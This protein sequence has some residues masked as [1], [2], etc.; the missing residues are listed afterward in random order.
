MSGDTTPGEPIGVRRS[1]TP[2]TDFPD[3]SAANV[4]YD[5]SLERLREFSRPLETTTEYGSPAYVS[6]FRSRSADRTRNDVDDRFTDEDWGLVQ[7][8]LE[9]VSRME[10][11]CLDRMVGRHPE[12]SYCCRL[13]VPREYGRIALAW[14]KLLDPA[15]EDRDPDFYTLQLPDW[16]E[17]AIRVLPDPGVTVVLGSDYTGEAKKSFLR[18]FMYRA[19]RR[20]GLGLHAGTKRLTLETEEGLSEVNQAFLGLSGTG[21]S[22]LTGHGCWLESPESAVMLQDD[23]CALFPD[24]LAGSEGGGLYIKT[25]GLDSEEQPALHRAATQPEAVL[26]NVAVDPDGTVDF[27]DGSLTTNGRAV[28]RREDLPSAAPEI[29]CE[30]ADQVFFITRN[31]LMPPIARLTPEQAAVAFMLGESVETSAGDPD[32]AGESIRVVGT[33]PFIVGPEGEEGNRFADLMSE[34]DAECFVLNTGSVGSKGIEVADT[35]SILTAAA[36]EEI[37]WITDETLGFEVPTRVPGVEIGAFHPQENNDE[38][39]SKLAALREERREYL[40]GFETLREEIR[41]A[42]Y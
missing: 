20:G 16:E 11:V 6:E 5:P 29:D 12:H 33:N 13:F 3:P 14:A 2:E 26:E 23:V 8:A 10:L 30:R 24:T 34:T 21:K 1:V 37:E 38:Y 25:I 27:D 4:T 17:T 15:S 7:R 42:I 28:I 39:E 32:R 35:I 40:A 9:R 31:P 18:L 41:E 36:R 19:K 22:T